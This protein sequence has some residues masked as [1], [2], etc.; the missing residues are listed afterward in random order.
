MTRPFRVALAVLVCVA[1]ASIPA[2]AAP[3]PGDAAPAFSIPSARG[4][5][6][7]FAAYHGKPVY[8]NFFASWCDPC[9]QEAPVILSLSQK[10]R[11]KGLIVVGIDEL[12]D[13]QKA[14]GF[15]KKYHWPFPIGLDGGDLERSYG[16]IALPVHVFIGRDGKVSTYRLGQMQ[17][18][19]IEDAIKKIL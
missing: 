15:A 4:G 17:P 12:E 8:L 5:A 18:G 1:A 19:D 14:L 11:A 2:V 9:N 16:I 7:S 3:R 10:Y 6:L 13:A